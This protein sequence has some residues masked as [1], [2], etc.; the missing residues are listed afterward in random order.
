MEV[1]S[2]DKNGE[3]LA[4]RRHL[5]LSNKSW[6]LFEACPGIAPKSS[7]KRC[8]C[9]LRIPDKT[10]NITPMKTWKARCREMLAKPTSPG[11]VKMTSARTL[12]L[13]RR[14]LTNVS[15]RQPCRRHI[16]PNVVCQGA[17]ASSVPRRKPPRKMNATLLRMQSGSIGPPPIVPHNSSIRLH[18]A[19]NDRTFIANS[20]SWCRKILRFHLCIL[21]LFRP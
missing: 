17:W 5:P 8:V 13:W 7:A 3:T 15:R 20:R 9:L 18:S 4:G 1:T 6:G 2:G 16:V 11:C 21:H 10:S 14:S 12:S 19:K